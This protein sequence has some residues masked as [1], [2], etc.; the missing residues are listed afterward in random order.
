MEN[1]FVQK[2]STNIEVKQ[3]ERQ[4][5][6]QQQQQPQSN[7][8]RIQGRRYQSKY[9]FFDR[10]FMFSFEVKKTN[11]YGINGGDES[12]EGQR[13]RTTTKKKIIRFYGCT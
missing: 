5:K 10:L 6:Q 7:M 12:D 11:D 1:Q 13:M 4:K 9:T 8:F 3:W 2:L